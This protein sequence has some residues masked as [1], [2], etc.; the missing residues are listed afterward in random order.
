MC[1]FYFLTVYVAF[2]DCSFCFLNVS[3]FG[4]RFLSLL[5]CIFFS[6][7]VLCWWIFSFCFVVYSLFCDCVFS[8]FFLHWRNS[9]SETVYA[10]LK[11]NA[12]ITI[13]EHPLKMFFIMKC[14]LWLRTYQDENK[15]H[16]SIFV[17]PLHVEMVQNNYLLTS[18][19]AYA[20]YFP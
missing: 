11:G 7:V 12:K 13:E 2:L 17:F 15:T 8:G 10:S 4:E 1:I 18:Q 5:L 3:I 20:K 14:M 16:C 9:K 6:Q 19:P